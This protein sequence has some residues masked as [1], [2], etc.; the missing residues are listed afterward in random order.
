MQSI[1]EKFDSKRNSIKE[2]KHW[3]LLLRNDQVTLGSLV[4][5]EKSFKNKYSEISSSSFIEFGEIIK[6]IEPALNKLFSYKKINYLMLMMRDDEV[7]YHIIPRYSEAKNFNSIEFI[8]NGWPALPDMTFH[9]PL[10]TQTALKLID[11]LK[12]SLK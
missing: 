9:N 6:K 11:A 12:N 1:L 8:D 10:D 3:H 4:L 7:H 2:Y 5:I